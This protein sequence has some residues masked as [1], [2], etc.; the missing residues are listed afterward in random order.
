MKFL[1]IDDISVLAVDSIREIELREHETPARVYFIAKDSVS[2]SDTYLEFD[3]KESAI[4][5]F[6]YII[7]ELDLVNPNTI[8]FEK[9]FGMLR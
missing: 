4:G 7:G 6:N 1:Q 9:T 3:S 8:N 2:D 5:Y